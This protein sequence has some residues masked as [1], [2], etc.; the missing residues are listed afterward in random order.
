MITRS[1]AVKGILFAVLTVGLVLYIGAHFLGVFTFLGAKP[2]T[3]M[4]P[5]ADANGLFP[6]SE[7][8][9]RGVK[10]GEISGIDLTATGTMV[11][12]KIDGDGPK[13]PA[14]LDVVLADRTAV[15]ERYIM[16]L[17]R[18]QAG[19]YLHDG[20]V[21]PADRVQTPVPVQTVLSSLDKLVSSVP[22]DD[23]RTTVYELGKGFDGLG[24]KLQLLLDST[25]SLTHTAQAVLPQTLSL[26][27]DSQT[28]LRTQNDLADPIKSF[29]SDLKK[30]AQQLKDSDPDIR[31]IAERG[32]DTFKEVDRLVDDVGPGLGRV[33]REGYR[34]AQITDSHLRDLQSVLQLYP[35]LAAAVP[36][37]LPRAS[38][39]G[40]GVGTARLGL[41]LNINDPPP[42]VNGYQ[43]T[44]RRAGTDIT[45]QPVNYR[46]QCAEPIYSATDVRGVKPGYPFKN[47]QPTPAPGWYNRFYRDG[48]AAG[49]FD[50]ILGGRR[51]GRAYE[52][53]GTADSTAGPFSF[54]T[55]LLPGH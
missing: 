38:D 15:G 46:A 28:V 1:T 32:P 47:G 25:N 19:P 11:N 5:V 9:Y 7:I 23:L 42:C 3:V 54:L 13:I 49:I 37:I 52:P 6:R 24:P 45:P 4:V 33:F 48:P 44:H 39:H 12:L 22:L 41:E 20:S 40:V 17:P 10:A 18:T 36:T 8:D 55:N 34:T 53:Y 29:S 31:R 43:A 14:D 30:V 50:P 51:D 16:L 26:I 21:V 27:R 35:G 2:Y